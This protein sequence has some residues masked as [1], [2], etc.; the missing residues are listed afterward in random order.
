MDGG[1]RIVVGRP[2]K[3][4]LE[5]WSRDMDA[6]ANAMLAESLHYF[7]PRLSR[8]GSF[9]AYRTILDGEPGRRLAW[10]KRG[11]SAQTVLPAGFTNAWDWSADGARILHACPTPTK[12]PGFCSSPRDISVA[13]STRPI[14]SDADHA[15]Y[16]GRFSPDDRWV[17]FN[18]QSLKVVGTSVLGLA[19]GSG[20][21]WTPLTDASLWADKPRWAPDGRTIYFF[22]NRNGQFFDVWGLRFDP[23][24]GRTVG[25]PFRVTHT[26]SPSRTID[27]SAASEL[28]VSATRLVLPMLEATGSIWILDGVMR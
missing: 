27:M 12:T 15:I 26:E 2:G 24:T 28:G 10:M 6:G 21:T 14:V 1:W 18:A 11:V 7:T 9:V 23:A 4:A 20:G 5:L 3:D 25:D 13:T 22:S 17:L 8:D 19:P 16:Q